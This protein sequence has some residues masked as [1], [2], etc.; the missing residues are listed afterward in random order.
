MRETRVTQFEKHWL[1]RKLRGCMKRVSHPSKLFRG[2]FFV[3]TLSYGKL[4]C[5]DLGIVLCWWNIFSRFLSISAYFRYR[6]NW[7][8]ILLE[9]FAI[10][11]SS[12]ER[13][14]ALF[15]AVE[16]G[17]VLIVKELLNAGANTETTNKVCKQGTWCCRH[18]AMHG[19]QNGGL[20]FT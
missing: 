15:H 5:F 12:Q 3:T 19:I 6:L 10:Y 18:R 16:K 14:T 20:L 7:F 17:H 1:Y 9:Q 13:K 4:A 8:R 2:L 11:F